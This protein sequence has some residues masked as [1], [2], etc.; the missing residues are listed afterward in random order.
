MFWWCNCIGCLVMLRQP[1][2]VSASRSSSASTG[3]N[4]D[5]AWALA[6][7][8]LVTLMRP[9]WSLAFGFL[10]HY[11]THVPKLASR[12]PTLLRPPLPAISDEGNIAMDVPGAFLPGVRRSWRPPPRFGASAS[13]RFKRPPHIQFG[14]SASR[15]VWRPPPLGFGATACGRVWRPPPGLR[16]LCFCTF[17]HVSA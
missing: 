1:H 2:P 7:E 10:L 13:G 16:R 14:A 5:I 17:R 8:P 6:P 4:F 11:L 12:L 15:R 9:Q 3:G